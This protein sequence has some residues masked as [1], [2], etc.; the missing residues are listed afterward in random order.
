MHATQLFQILQASLKIHH[1]NLHNGQG[2][3]LE[4]GDQSVEIDSRQEFAN[5][6]VVKGGGRW[7]LYQSEPR[8]EIRASEPYLGVW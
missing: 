1:N 8:G 2:P 3:C 7:N 6:R 5:I 4:L